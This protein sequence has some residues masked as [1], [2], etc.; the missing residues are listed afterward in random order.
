MGVL[1]YDCDILAVVDKSF[2]A[3]CLRALDNSV[4]TCKLL[5]VDE[6]EPS[7]ER[8]GKVDGMLWLPSKDCKPKKTWR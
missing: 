1:I 8:T 5:E 4:L 6:T 7:C 3:A 2:R